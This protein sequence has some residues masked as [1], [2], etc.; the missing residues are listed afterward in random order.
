MSKKQLAQY[1]NPRDNATR[2]VRLPYGE[3]GTEA[4]V[5]RT[6]LQNYLN[7]NEFMA[8]KEGFEDK[9]KSV[10]E[11]VRAETR[12]MKWV[13][14]VSL[15]LA[16]LILGALFIV[17]P[18]MLNREDAKAI[19]SMKQGMTSFEKALNAKFIELNARIES[20]TR[21]RNRQKPQEP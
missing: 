16:T 1:S 2:T 11:P 17:Y 14:G 7:R 8:Y 4:L 10:I 13:F 20:V 5:D 21:I 12:N 19:E 15:L 9:I 18:N 3:R 6:E